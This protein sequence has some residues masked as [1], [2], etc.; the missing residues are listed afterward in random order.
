MNLHN[1]TGLEEA[2]VVGHDEIRSEEAKGSLRRRLELRSLLW[3]VKIYMSMD[4]PSINNIPTIDLMWATRF[5]M[6]ALTFSIDALTS[7]ESL[8]YG[9]S[10]SATTIY[11]SGNPSPFST[12]FTASTW[13]LNM[14][15]YVI[16]D[17]R[18]YQLELG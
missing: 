10:V 3:R 17:P 7:S 8:Q 2:G 9:H 18:S 6:K 1:G 16:L 13:A 4:F 11:A 15:V 12:D 5:L 14:L